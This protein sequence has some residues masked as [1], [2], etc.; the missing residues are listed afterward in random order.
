MKRRRFMGMLGAAGW[1]GCSSKKEAVETWKGIVMGIEVSI[2]FRGKENTE[3]LGQLAENEAKR[4]EAIFSLWQD[5]SELARLNQQKKIK[6]SPDL[7]ACLKLARELY[8]KSNG[9]FDPTIETYQSWLQDE[10]IEGRDPDEEARAVKRQ[11]VDFSK[12][13]I[14]PQGVILRP[15]VLISLNAIAQGYLTDRIY[16]LLEKESV[17]SALVN[18]GEYRVVGQEA[19]PV[20]I[21][22]KNEAIQLKTALAVSSGSGKRMTATSTENHLM[23]PASGKSPEARKT[24]AVIADS[25]ALA[26]GLATIAAV[27]GEIPAS[28]PAV[29]LK[30][31]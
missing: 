9:A 7:F 8:E 4:L 23:H 18:F 30:V 10:L 11:L 12:V 26:D 25:A 21:K 24:Y 5:D 3:K 28:Y 29:T 6:P 20:T 16:E 22:G 15:E 17:K 13:K 14:S 2:R 1:A 19:W 27:T 31:C